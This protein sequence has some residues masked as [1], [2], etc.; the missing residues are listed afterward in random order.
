MGGA[1]KIDPYHI[2]EGLDL[3][4]TSHAL[5]NKTTQRKNHAR[6]KQF[7][8]EKLQNHNEAGIGTSILIF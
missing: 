2:T 5:N 8:K 6:M 7:N 1:S 4:I 3:T